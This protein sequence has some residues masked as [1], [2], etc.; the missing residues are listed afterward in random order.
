M[1]QGLACGLVGAGVKPGL[2][3]VVAAGV[4]L[5]TASD[6]P[7]KWDQGSDQTGVTGKSVLRCL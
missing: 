5:G 4:S 1:R 6:T 3:L 7:C 2:A